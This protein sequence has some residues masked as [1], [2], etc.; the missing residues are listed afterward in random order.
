MQILANVDICRQD[1]SQGR[2]TTFVKQLSGTLSMKDTCVGIG[3]HVD[4]KLQK[5]M[6]IQPAHDDE[7]KLKET[8]NN[9]IDWIGRLMM[10][11]MMM[12]IFLT[13]F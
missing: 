6:S 2:P 12:S 5:V 3:C 7:Q 8:A 4:A 10:M 9:R 11:L 13:S 1:C